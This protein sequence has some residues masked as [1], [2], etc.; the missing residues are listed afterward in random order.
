MRALASTLLLLATP[1]LAVLPEVGPAGVSAPVQL[2]AAAA[3]TGA[4]APTVAP[5]LMQPAREAAAPA[6]RL[7]VQLGPG[8]RLAPAATPGA[9]ADAPTASAPTPAKPAAPVVPTQATIEKI[10]LGDRLY[11]AG[12]YRNA[13][14]AYQDAV[15]QQPRYPPA[16][17]RLGRAYLALRYPALAIAQAEAALAEDPASVE[18]G[19]LVEESKNPSAR[20]AAA[21]PPPAGPTSPG[22]EQGSA[23]NA[24]RVYRFTPDAEAAA[25]SPG[26][27][28]PGRRD[29]A[30]APSH[31]VDPVVAVV[32][33]A[34]A[35]PEP[36][37]TRRSSDVRVFQAPG[38]APPPDAASPPPSSGTASPPGVTAAQHYRTALGHLQNRDWG[39]A[40]A[41]LSD[42]IRVDPKLAVAYA[43]R[44]SAQ[45]GLGK[46]GDAA[47]DYRAALVLDPALATPV[48]G[49][50]ECYRVLGDAKRAAEMYERY[51]RAGSSDVREDLRAIA[52]KRAQ[53]LR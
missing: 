37:S 53:E 23:R 32:V 51:S 1:A 21:P 38:A 36:A 49:L 44:G 14:F 6:A 15:F 34:P 17:V 42:A 40:V 12:D 27:P 30:T 46:Y 3:S 29:G 48:Y 11:L 31:A 8:T 5:V 19:K 25:G 41:E 24:P 39:K 7:P 18:A 45:F 16:R 13:L 4:G 28:P 22:A 26:T 35:D 20:P 43:A 47:E 10:G 50:A 33:A 9:A 52:A 2:G